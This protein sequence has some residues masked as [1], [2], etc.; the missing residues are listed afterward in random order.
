MLWSR[1]EVSG[2]AKG[3]FLMD[4]SN[5]GEKIVMAGLTSTLRVQAAAQ[6]G[7]ML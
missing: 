6:F 2:M 3:K 5:S 4:Q 1:L 7:A